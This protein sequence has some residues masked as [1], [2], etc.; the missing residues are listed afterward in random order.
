MKNILVVGCGQM[1]EDYAKVLVSLG[2]PFSVSGR[3]MEKVNAFSQK[4]P[5]AQVMGGGVSAYLASREVPEYA[6][7]AVNVPALAETTSLLVNAGVRHVLVEKP[8]G[9]STAEIAEINALAMEK[10]ASVYVA[11]NRRFYASVDLAREIILKD[12]G[13]ISAQFEFTEWVHVV[14]KVLVDPIT[15][16]RLVLANST[17]VIDLFVHL[18]GRPRTLHADVCG[19]P[20]PWHP[21][22]SIFVG[23]GRTSRD[24]PFTY[25]AN[26]QAPGRWALELLTASHRL[27]FKPMEK[28][29]VQQKGS[30]RIEE[31]EGDY[32]VDVNFKPGL[33]RQVEAFVYGKN[34]EYLCAISE[35]LMNFPAYEKIAGY[36]SLN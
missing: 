25:H 32:S 20:I 8:A 2:L 19:N 26:W 36:D 9:V 29:M 21:A 10:G 33:L 35:H 7:V 30:V 18:C 6:I 13:V 3:G 12:G 11:Y 34:R 1:A 23:S 4:Y 22:G 17:H 14:E 31:V 28:L 27:Y 15:L 24:I 5:E 16:S